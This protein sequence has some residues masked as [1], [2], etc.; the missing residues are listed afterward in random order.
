MHK[1]SLLVVI[2]LPVIALAQHKYD[3]TWMF[4]PPNPGLG[5]LI[6]FNTNQE[7]LKKGDF[8]FA[9]GTGTAMISDGEGKLQYYSVGCHIANG[10]HTIVPGADTLNPGWFYDN[11]CFNGFP[12]PHGNQAMVFLPF[13]EYIYK[14]VYKYKNRKILGPGMV[15]D[16]IDTIYMAS[17]TDGN[18]DY[19]NKAIFNDTLSFGSMAAVKHANGEDYWLVT[20]HDSSDIYFSI[21]ISVDGVVEIYEQ[22]VD[23]V[24]R[25]N[26]NGVI[27]KFSPHG[28]IYI[29]FEQT[30]FE[31]TLKVFSF[32]RFTGELELLYTLP[33]P[34]EM[35]SLVGGIEFS[36]SGRYL[37]VST[38]FHIYQYDL[39]ATDVEGSKTLVAE[40]D[41]FSDP[42]PCTF[43]VMQLG[44][45][46][47]IYINT[48]NSQ[49][50]LHVIMYPD[51][52]GEACEVRQHHIPLY[53]YHQISMPYFPNFRLGTGEPVCDSTLSLP[54]SIPIVYV[55]E[56]GLRVWPNPARG[57][58]WVG[59]SEALIRE[60]VG[61][62]LYDMMGR[63]VLHQPYSGGEVLTVEL[64]SLT[65][66]LYV[67]L[68]QGRDG[69]RWTEKLIV[70]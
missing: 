30:Y 42:F 57:Q 18:L 33:H 35:T 9:I 63:Q 52:P 40:W 69:R 8:A 11:Y 15:D 50:W 22:V 55:P 5:T 44:P 1:Y 25:R 43:H 12:Y 3:Y 47:R 27:T 68:V 16:I 32:D 24:L 7:Q 66:G 54:T 56:G 60:A 19:V 6:S 2:F 21:H 23:G 39:E 14:L 13:N 64:H 58:V 26:H 36:P 48:S 41:G 34:E 31:Q 29:G 70:E 51:R 4:G 49:Q 38:R 17:L 53:Y 61:L 37:Y 46:C 65:P 10:Q 28:T 67:L 45:D 62:T 20:P 59:L